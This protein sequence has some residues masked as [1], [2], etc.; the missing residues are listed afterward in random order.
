MKLNRGLPI[1][2]GLA[3]LVVLSGRIATGYEPADQALMAASGAPP[4]GLEIGRASCRE[5]V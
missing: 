5:R 3:M 4:L 1:S 2:A